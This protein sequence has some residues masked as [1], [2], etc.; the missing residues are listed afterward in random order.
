MDFLEFFNLN[1]DPFRLT[2]DPFYFYPSESHN[3]LLSS[4]NYVIEQ[5]EGFF[6]AIGEPGTGKTTVLKV[7]INTWKDKALIALV[8]TPRLSPEEFLATVLEDLKVKVESTNKNDIIRTFRDFLVETALK[9]TRVIIIVDEAQNMPFETLEEL[10]LLSNL[11]TEKEKLLQI[12]LIGQ[13]Q[14]R[15]IL[16]SPDLKQLNQRVTVRCTLKP[17]SQNET[18]DYI[19]YRLIK[20][21]KGSVSFEKDACNSVYAYS[22]GIPRLINLVS[23][24]AMM[25]AY[26]DGSNNVTKQHVTYTIKHLSDDD[27]KTT[28]KEPSKIGMYA[29]RFVFL[30][31][32]FAI[33]VAI[34]M[35]YMPDIMR[36]NSKT[37]TVNPKSKI[38]SPEKP[39]LQE[40]QKEGKEQ[41]TDMRSSI[42]V[43]EKEEKVELSSEP[44]AEVATEKVEE[45]ITETE[46]RNI[47]RVTASI[48][49]NSANIREKP[50]LGTEVVAWITKDMDFEI[51]NKIEDNEGRTWYEIHLADGREG[52]ISGNI[53]KLAK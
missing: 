1:E 40:P 20:G 27:I 3:E 17:L 30:L 43:Q 50:G 37:A 39:G 12:V 36:S 24:R 48:T 49:V 14:L 6:L 38:K 4:L 32:I 26:L 52:W 44:P 45:V 11:E 42:N 13:H 53:I 18:N 33:V 35:N 22:K 16:G 25:S 34:A 2:P 28:G 10:R 51:K 29:G 23:S 9:D 41:G 31:I 8:M 5:K 21:G 46:E 7:F 15:K 19:N 47:E